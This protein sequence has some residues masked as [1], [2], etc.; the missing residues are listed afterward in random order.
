MFFTAD[1]HFSDTGMLKENR[2]PFSSIG[3]MDRVMITNWNRVVGKEDTVFHIGDFAGR[4]AD[5]ED[6][7]S[8]L[9]GNII[10]ICGNHDRQRVR[11]AVKA[12]ANMMELRLSDAW[13]LLTHRPL[14]ALEGVGTGPGGLIDSRGYDLILCGHSHERERWIG[15]NCLNVGV[16]VH[17]FTPVS[18]GRVVQ[19]WRER[20]KEKMSGA[21]QATQSA[22]AT[23]STR[24]AVSVKR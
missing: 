1:T 2:R 18:A 8:R 3:E 4:D 22:Q 7:I 24:V 21:T 19:L 6:I 20:K 9:N 23:E 5:V 12:A 15:S 11:K 14:R 17:L 16:D 13:C 10:L